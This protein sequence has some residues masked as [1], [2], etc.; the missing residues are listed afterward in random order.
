[1]KLRL[2]RQG[3][4]FYLKIRSLVYVLWWANAFS[5]FSHA[6]HHLKQ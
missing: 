5:V 2:I 3:E 1:M 4:G 6:G